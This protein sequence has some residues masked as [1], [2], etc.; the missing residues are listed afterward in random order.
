[1]SPIRLFFSPLLL[2]TAIC[3]GQ[4]QADKNQYTIQSLTIWS[5]SGIKAQETTVPLNYQPQGMYVWD[6]WYLQQGDTTHMFHL[7]V[8]RPG[9]NRPGCDEGSIGHAV[10]TDLIHWKELP[11]ALYS[12]TREAGKSYDDETLF[13]GSAIEFKGVIYN[14]YC[15]NTTV[16][17]GEN[18]PTW[19]QSM[20]LA[21]ST[22]GI[23]FTKYKNNPVIEPS[24][25]RY[26]NV[27]E[28]RAPFPHHA[29]GGVDCR[30]MMVIKDPFGDGWLGYTVMRRQGQKDAEHSICIVLCRSKDL[31]NWVVGDPVATPDRFN[32]FEVPDVFE[33]DGK[34]YMIALTG[35]AYGQKNRWSDAEISCATIV[36]ES[37]SPYGPFI[38]VKDNLLLASKN[39]KWEGFSARTVNRKGER[40]MLFSHAEDKPPHGR[41]SWAVK[42]VPQKNGG[43]SPIYWKGND[44][45][46]SDA[47]VREPKVILKKGLRED[48]LKTSLTQVPDEDSVYMVQT[49]IQ[50]FREA[51]VEFGSQQGARGNGYQVILSV[52]S[53]G[54]GIIK[55]IKENNTI[56][57]TR[58]WQLLP[59]KK[60]RL[61]LIVVKEVVEVFLDDVLTIDY[62]LNDLVPGKIGFSAADNSGFDQTTY[63]SSKRD[64]I[65]KARINPEQQIRL[66]HRT[67]NGY[68]GDAIPFWWNAGYHVFC[69]K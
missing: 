40:L 61:R 30:D 49:T 31:Y 8:R 9:S 27:F 43:L 59:D 32:C 57:T 39:D 6:T 47:P 34:W 64:S 5:S 14:F 22:D 3:G 41:L 19:R 28:P 1:M 53:K 11:T 10:S 21:T 42:L 4:Q 66:N 69:L 62:F 25:G 65:R 63:Y 44:K 12:G 35:D 16:H 52:S 38:E 18:N 33:L 48:I 7:Q 29:L 37:R 23:H 67:D 60:Y 68:F 54:T 58:N 17:F 45:A 2:F 50:T 56:L 15:G 55:L 26:Y 46:F 36:F 51:G 20:C 24:K 13:T